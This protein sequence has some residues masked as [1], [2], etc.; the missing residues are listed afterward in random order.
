[1]RKI[2]KA[3]KTA[4][5]ATLMVAYVYAAFALKTSKHYKYNKGNCN[6]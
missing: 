5:F 1:M 2:R 6:V 3:V 4:A